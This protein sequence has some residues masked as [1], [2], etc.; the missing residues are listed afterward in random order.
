MTSL[1][2]IPHSPPAAPL[3]PANARVSYG[4]IWAAFGVALVA[5]AGS[6]W[7][8]IGMHLKACPLCYYQRTFVMA[9]VGVLGIGLL[10][11]AHRYGLLSLLALPAVVGGLG[12]AVWHEYLRATGAMDCPRG[13]F[14][15]SKT[16]HESLAVLA[17]LFVLL[18]IDALR[19]QGQK[20]VVWSATA[21][22]LALG[23]LF[24]VGAVQSVSPPPG[25]YK[26]PVDQDGCRKPLILIPP[27]SLRLHERRIVPI[28][29]PLSKQVSESTRHVRGV[30]RTAGR[31]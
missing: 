7:L 19:S 8:S 5:L 1:D 3:R 27:E 14:G 22:A 18:V 20:I 10:T 9:A 23:L 13:V 17:L 28:A 29:L 12:V 15:F 11:G 31:G 25:D 2:T 21:G 16:T 30:A 26:L 24:T 6:L 4:L